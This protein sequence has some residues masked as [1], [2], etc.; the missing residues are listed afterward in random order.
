MAY[1]F[2]ENTI[3]KKRHNCGD[4]KRRYFLVHKN[5]VISRYTRFFENAKRKKTKNDKSRPSYLKNKRE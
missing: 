1:I 4:H 5:A 3:L 2:E